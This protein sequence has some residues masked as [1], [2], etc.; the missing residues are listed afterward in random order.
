[1]VKL[2]AL[3]TYLMSA[4]GVMF[5]TNLILKKNKDSVQHTEKEDDLFFNY[6]FYL[7]YHKLV[8]I[9]LFYLPIFLL[10]F[11]IFEAFFFK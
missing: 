7:L 2:A 1:M 11:N 6:L 5:N 10:N 9:F 4:V 8:V 3:S